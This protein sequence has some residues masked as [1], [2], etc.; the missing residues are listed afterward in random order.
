MPGV[1]VMP[2]DPNRSRHGSRLRLPWPLFALAAITLV[3]Y[4]LGP[5]EGLIYDRTAIAQGEL[6]RLVTGHWI[7]SDSQ[8][9][10][11]NV[12]AFVL[13]G[14]AWRPSAR[15][16]L[17]GLMAGIGAV[18][19]ALFWL[20]P[21]L[22]YYCGLSGVLNTALV[23][24]LVRL[25]QDTRHPLI[26]AVAIGAMCK[27]VVELALQQSLFS[28]T[29]WPPVPEAHLAG[30]LAGVVLVSQRLKRIASSNLDKLNTVQ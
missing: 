1:S 18:S 26:V 23:L 4:A 5:Q 9:L 11:L 16:L 24:A 3:L 28:Q 12:T 20:M 17:T 25:W 29:L 21:A 15:E 2:V 6:W 7:H 27:I 10:M 30:F 19:A 14:T 13:L 22:S 8:H